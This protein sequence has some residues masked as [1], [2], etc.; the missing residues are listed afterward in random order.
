[1][2]TEDVEAFDTERGFINIAPKYSIKLLTSFDMVSCFEK[3][4]TITTESI[5]I[6][7]TKT[8][9]VHRYRCASVTI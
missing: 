9:H 5:A 2:V 7:D 6:L 3:C 1:M 4:L 8:T